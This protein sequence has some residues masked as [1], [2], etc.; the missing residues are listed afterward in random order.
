MDNTAQ[1]NRMDMGGRVHFA[2]SFKEFS[3]HESEQET[4]M[5]GEDVFI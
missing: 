1:R 2:R 5:R 3:Q 4:E